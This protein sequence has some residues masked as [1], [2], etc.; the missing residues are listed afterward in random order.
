MSPSVNDKISR[1]GVPPNPKYS[2]CPDEQSLFNTTPET[3]KPGIPWP[4][5]CCTVHFIPCHIILCPVLSCHAMPSHPILFVLNEFHTLRQL[6]KASPF[7]SKP[8]PS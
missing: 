3:R 7:D 4:R 1:R 2:D 8:E 6:V 5:H